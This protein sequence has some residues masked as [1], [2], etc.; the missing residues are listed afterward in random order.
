M[1][2]HIFVFF[3]IITLFGSL[4]SVSA[5]VDSAIGQITD[6]ESESFVGGISGDGRLVVF[7]STGN[8]ATENPRNAD[9]NRE[10]FLFDYAQRRIFQITDTKSL[11]TDPTMSI[12]LGNIKV[13]ISNLRPTISNDGRWIAFGSNVNSVAMPQA[14]ITPGNF[15]AASLNVTS[16]TT[17][18]NP[19]TDDGNTEI[20]LYQVPAVATVNLSAGA[21]LAIT[22]LSAG[23]F[24]RVTNTPA[25]RTPFP[26]S[27]TNGP[28]I[29]D[30]NRSATINNNG[31]YIA[32]VSN[33]DLV[34]TV[35]N[36]SPDN[37]DEI[38]TYVRNANVIGQVTKTPRG[39]SRQSDF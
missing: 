23:T 3:V 35:G 8:I 31:N 5:Q 7:E 14:G 13:E 9:G 38:F 34:P 6:S 27:A 28:I 30:D 26:G 4:S 25:S 16:G 22:D 12:T 21:E 19:L 29:A 17:V 2:F 24:T 15:D 18:T 11:L 37:N 10:I 39:H 1:K 33:R 32:F 20:W 36:A